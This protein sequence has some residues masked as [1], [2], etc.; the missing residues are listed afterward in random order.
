MKKDNKESIRKE[1]EELKSSLDPSKDT[2][3]FRVPDHFFDTL[4]GNISNRLSTESAKPAFV[5]PGLAFKR[6]IASIVSISLLV[7]ILFSL[8]LMQRESLNGQA[9]LD[10]DRQ[11][12][13]FYSIQFDMDRSALYDF[14][15]ESGL[16]FEDIL[17]E[18]EN[19]EFIHGEDVFD[20]MLLEEMFEQAI[21]YGIESNYLLSSLD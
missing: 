21:Y 5:F 1:L 4:P 13:E 11:M 19:G 18:L 6:L 2:G 8:F 16:T 17:F 20:D 15:L 12:Q 7:G 14:V 3:G 9:D 10:Y